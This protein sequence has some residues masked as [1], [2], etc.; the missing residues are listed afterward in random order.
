[1]GSPPDIEANVAPVETASA[2]RLVVDGSVT[3]PEI[4]LLQ[5]SLELSV[6]AGRVCSIRGANRNN[7]AFLEELLGPAGSPRRVVAECGVGL[8]PLARLTGAML[9]DEGAWGSVHIGLGSNSTIGGVNCAD[10]HLDFVIRNPTL[11][12]DGKECLPNGSTAL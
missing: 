5:T 6:H 3:C 12:I 10:F 1:L 9:T 2:G 11:S 4:G 8:N 7:A